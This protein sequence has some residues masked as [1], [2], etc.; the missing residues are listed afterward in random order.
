[1]QE[2]LTVL[3]PFTEELFE[4]TEADSILIAD[5]VVPDLAEIRSQWESEVHSRLKEAT[6]EIPDTMG[7]FATGGRRNGHHSEYMGYILAEMQALPRS[8]PDAKW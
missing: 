1:M 4:M 6:L 2:A 8:M 3:W 7:Y 5:K